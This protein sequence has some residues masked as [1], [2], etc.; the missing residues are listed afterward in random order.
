MASLARKT[1]P[2]DEQEQ[3]R[4]SMDALAQALRAK[5]IDALM[6]HYAGDMV[7]FDMRPP[8]R[9]S[10]AEAYRKNFEAWFASVQGLID[11]EIN[12][13]TVTANDNLGLSH[14]LAHVRS[15]RTTG[16]VADYWVRVTSGFQK[17]EGRWMIIHEHVSVPI[18]MA[19]GRAAL[20]LA[21]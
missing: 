5:D 7:T 17:I 20:D 11:Y 15:T 6:A 2:T 9:I 1:A 18:H 16:A 12:E 8:L 10:A 19:T 13:L 3:I 14:Y 4:E 21:P